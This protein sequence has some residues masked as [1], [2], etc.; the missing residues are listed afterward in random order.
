MQTS[1][2]KQY[3]FGRQQQANLQYKTSQLRQL[4]CR[5]VL[6]KIEAAALNPHDWQYYQ[7]M[8]NFYKLPL[9]LPALSLGHDISGEVVAIG[10]KVKKFAVGDKVYGMSAKTG[11]FGEYMALDKKMLARRPQTLNHLQAAAVPMAALTAWQMYILCSLQAGQSLLLNGASGGVGLFALQFAKHKGALVSTVSSARNIGLLEQFGAD[12]CLDY[13]AVDLKQPLIIDGSATAQKFDLVFDTVGSLNPLQSA[14]LMHDKSK[15]ATT[16]HN[17]RT[18]SACFL[19][20]LPFKKYWGSPFG[21]GQLGATYTLLALPIGKHLEQIATLIDAGK[22]KVVIDKIYP[23]EE[24]EKAI[25]YSKTG[26]AR[27]KIVLDIKK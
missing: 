9:P 21:I 23:I 24:L 25:A 18:F 19:A 14:H 17:W 15:F 3:K 7:F 6:I 4:S 16:M 1:S 10:S 12:N 27:G 13:N 11:A 22:V 26:R 2:F 5:Q 8:R 20:P